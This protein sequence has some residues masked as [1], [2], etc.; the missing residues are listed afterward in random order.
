MT[1]IRG[2]IQQQ[3]RGVTPDGTWNNAYRNRGGQLEVNSLQGMYDSWL[4]AGRVFSAHFATE[5]GFATLE[6]NTAVDLTEPFWRATVPA[7]TVMVPIKIKV[8]PAVVWETGDEYILYTSDTDTYTTGGAASD[9][10]GLFIDNQ[11]SGN[12]LSSTLTSVYDGDSALTEGAVTNPRILDFGHF[13][14]GGLYLPYEYNI[15]K[16]DPW[17][18]IHGP[19]S[20]CLMIARTT[21]TIECAYSVIWAELDKNELVNS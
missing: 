11:G 8:V 7:A 19:A 18:M 1:D 6:N 2:F 16:G 10:R 12:P 15:F 14:T 3:S 17:T 9:V 5:G 4:R 21:T 20:I 13:L